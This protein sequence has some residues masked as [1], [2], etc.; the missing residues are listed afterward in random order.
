MCLFTISINIE[1]VNAQDN[2]SPTFHKSIF[3]SKLSYLSNSVYNGRKDTFE[4]PYLNLS[5]KYLNSNGFYLNSGIS[6]LVS[7]YAQRVDLFNFSAGY[8]KSINDHFDFAFNLSKSFYDK[9]SVAVSSEILGNASGLI[10]YANKAFDLSMGSTV[11]FTSGLSD[12]SFNIDL[13]HSFSLDKIDQWALEPDVNANMGT[14]NYFDR[15]LSTRITKKGTKRIPSGSTTITVNTTTTTETTVEALNATKMEMLDIEVSLPLNY[16]GPKWGFY[17]LP[18]F[19]IPL[20]PIKYEATVT[21][22]ATV[23]SARPTV[24]VKTSQSTETIVNTFFGEIGITYK[25]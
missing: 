14:R 5:L 3:K 8:F 13:S 12:Y 22:T 18:T 20:S 10:S 16:R 6:Y 2:T 11:T 7:S 21:T 1:L 19:A 23:G 4:V 9:N 15:Y 24:T 17:I 25:F